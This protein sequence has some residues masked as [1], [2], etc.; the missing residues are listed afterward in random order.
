[1]VRS[2]AI[3]VGKQVWNVNI[4]PCLDTHSRHGS[5]FE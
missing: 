4:S 1:M 5:F 2:E 3:A